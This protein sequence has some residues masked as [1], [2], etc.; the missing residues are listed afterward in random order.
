MLKEGGISTTE[1]P[2]LEAERGPGGGDT[3]QA[4]H[5]HRWKPQSL[6]RRHSSSPELRREKSRSRSPLRHESRKERGRHAHRPHSPDERHRK[7]QG[8]KQRTATLERDAE[9]QP[10][11]EVSGV[12]HMKSDED[13]EPT[14]E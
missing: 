4:Q 6:N 13:S 11:R 9:H 12:M 8:A 10:R 3:P 14:S 1:D 5:I 2:G 7:R